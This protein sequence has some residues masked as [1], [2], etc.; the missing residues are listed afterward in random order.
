MSTVLKDYQ[1][2]HLIDVWKVQWSQDFIHKYRVTILPEDNANGKKLGS[3]NDGNDGKDGG[4]RNG[5][6]EHEGGNNDNPPADVGP[7]NGGGKDQAS[8]SGQDNQN[9]SSHQPSKEET[10]AKKQLMEELQYQANQG[11]I[12]DADQSSKFIH[13]KQE[14]V[15]EKQMQAPQ[16]QPHSL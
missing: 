4:N 9:Q 13:M 12:T 5:G 3:G 8:G 14:V 11:R 16:K 10:K 6:D 7:N 2:P 15:D 1:A